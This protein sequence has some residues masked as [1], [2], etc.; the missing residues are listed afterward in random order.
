[1]Q[2]TVQLPR[3]KTLMVALVLLVL[4]VGLGIASLLVTPPD[5]Q[6]GSGVAL[7]G[8]PFTMVNQTGAVVTEK[9]FAGKYMLVFFGYTYCPD[10]CPA[11]LQVMAN[12]LD[13]L[14]DKA[15]KVAPVFV[16]IDPARDDV[17][18]IKAYVEAIDPRLTGLTGTPEQ[19]AAIT[20]AYK[21]FYAKVPNEK[22][23]Q[24]YLMDH[25]S[26]L[27]LMGPDGR[28]LK[29]FNYTIESAKLTKALDDLVR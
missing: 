20:A 22:R 17:A 12:A 29:H 2:N 5:H 18:T 13:Q 6:Q 3:R 11:T 28:F 4:A 7:V 26:L 8:G 21:V 27:F 19:V 10:V 24:D 9:D 1:M 14:G 15:K 25:S 16:T 23:P